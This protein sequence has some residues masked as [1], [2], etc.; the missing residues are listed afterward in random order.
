LGRIAKNRVIGPIGKQLPQILRRWT[1]M[2]HF[3]KREEKGLRIV[4]SGLLKENY[5]NALTPELDEW[6]YSERSSSLL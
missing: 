4:W 5:T 2:F 3:E 1:Q 6:I